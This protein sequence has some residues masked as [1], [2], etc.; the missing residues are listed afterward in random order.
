MSLRGAIE[1]NELCL[2]FQPILGLGS[3]PTLRLEALVRWRHPQLG[4]LGPGHFFS[5][6]EENGLAAMIG[7]WVLKEAAASPV[8]GKPS[9]ARSASQ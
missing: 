4:L 9:A 1:R 7:N 3:E 8:C 2:F 6:A 5:L